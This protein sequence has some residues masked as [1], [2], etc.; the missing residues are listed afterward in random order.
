MIVP[1]FKLCVGI[2][3]V[4]NVLVNLNE[5]RRFNFFPG[6]RESGLGDESNGKISVIAELKESIQFILNRPFDK[7]NHKEE[8]LIK[9]E[10][11][12]SGEIF[13]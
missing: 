2:E 8:K 12:L 4:T 7:I 5:C 6:Q 11:G 9:S 13:W 10:Y 1:A 3:I